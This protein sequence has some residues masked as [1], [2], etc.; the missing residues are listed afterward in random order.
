M[1]EVYEALVAFLVPAGKIAGFL[2]LCK[3][4]VSVVY[5]AATGKGNFI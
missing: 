5:R 1:A 2:A 4:G 3:I